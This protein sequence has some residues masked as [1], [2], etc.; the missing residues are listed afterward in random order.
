MLAESEYEIRILY[1]DDHLIEN[2]S[3]TI[4][5]SIFFPL[6]IYTSFSD[7]FGKDESEL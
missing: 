1:I 5:Y 6:N 3:I 2:I 4:L 7:N